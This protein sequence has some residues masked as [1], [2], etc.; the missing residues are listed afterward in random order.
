MIKHLTLFILLIISESAIS[1]EVQWVSEV[2]DFSS[3]LSDK[4]FSA[5]QIIGKPDV[6]PQG[7]D[8]PNAWLPQNP[9]KMDYIK[10][11]FDHPSRIQ[12]IVIA[13][14]FNP[15][16]SYQVFVYDRS[17]KEY[18]LN[19]FTPKPIP[20]KGR[21]L[22]LF[23]EKTPYEVNS[24]KLVIDGLSVPGYNGID[25]I[26]ISDSRIPVEAVIEEALNVSDEINPE[27]LGPGINSE[28]EEI[29]PIVS[30][31]GKTMYFSRKNHPE[32]IGGT[33]DPE[34]IWYSIYDMDI[35]EWIEAVNPGVPLNNKDAN[36]VSSITPD[37]KSLTMILGNKYQKSKKMKPGVSVTTK[38][39]TGWSEP[40][41]VNINN[42]FI[43]DNDGHYSL[44]QNRNTMVMAINRFDSF[45]RKDIYVTFLLPDG[46]W[47]EP[48][49]LGNTINTSND[50][51]S[52]FMAAD[53]ETLYFSSKGYSGFGGYDIYISR[54][55]DDSW[56][57]WSEPENL[58]RPINSTED[59]VFFVISPVGEYAYYS[60]S[61]T[62]MD[63][64]IFR[65]KLPIF[66]QPEP[67]VLMKGQI[68]KSGTREPVSARIKYEKFPEETEAGYT[69]S[70]SISGDYEI[71][72]P[73]GSNY[74]Y[75]LDI[76]GFVILEDT[77]S[78][79]NQKEYK[80]IDKDLY[81]DTDLLNQAL[82]S[83]ALTGKDKPADEL[84]PVESKEIV[85]EINDGV[86]SVGVHFSFDSDVIWKNSYL[87]LDRIVNLL[88]STPVNVVLA[89]HTD[90][91]GPETYNLILSEKRANSVHRYLIDKG[92]DPDKITT[93]GYG[94]SRPLTSNTTKEGRRR[95]RRVDFIRADQMD[96]YDQK[97]GQ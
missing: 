60:R 34:D 92:I 81:I 47:N 77:I 80:E 84:K 28:Y 4:E 13:E 7:G 54:R 65:I 45:G 39:S 85:M 76:K 49:N 12:Q 57:N 87:H 79:I 50:E 43:E 37:G 89:G 24:L 63:A 71:V 64:D 53:N 16:A 22:H 48:L 20:Q 19:T 69:K 78:L 8:S 11:W 9:D 30:P 66:F 83:E 26:G 67:I 96:L 33:L 6:L 31:D 74:K 25:A 21:L 10:V 88:K 59:D 41:H 75:S 32:N 35:Q 90:N 51:N 1:Q 42:A 18:L 73:L 23:F 5:K 82:M 17:G 52:P 3:E 61:I 14:S 27:K 38:R 62:Q 40:V 93:L 2:I 29:R 97:N 86:L 15:S 91:T 44:N 36:Y 55:L 56:T 95:N 70:D 46:S 94:E 68:F 58:G 72:F